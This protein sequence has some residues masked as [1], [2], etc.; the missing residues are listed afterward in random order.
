[1]AIGMELK[2]EERTGGGVALNFPVDDEETPSSSVQKVPPRRLRRRLLELK[3]PTS[4]EE[5]EAKLREADLRRQQFYE[6]LSSRARKMQNP[7][8]PCQEGEQL[9]RMLA[10]C[11]R[12]FVRLKKTTFALAK[13]YEALGISEKDVKLMPFEQLVLKLESASTI[14]TVK[15]LVD[16]LE[17]RI[18]LS[19]TVAGGLSSL[20]N[21]DHL[22]KQLATQNRRGNTSNTKKR[23][24][25]KTEASSKK[26]V[27]STIRPPRYPVRVLLCAY[28][29]VGHPDA[30]LSSK[31]ESETALVEVAA[32]FVQ[33]FELIIKMIIDGP[34][35]ISEKKTVSATPTQK[36]FRSQ[37]E[38]FDKAWCTYL[39]HFV[40]WKVKD[41]KLLEEDLVRAARDLELSMMHKLSPGKDDG[42]LMH[43]REAIQKQVIEN[44]KI[45]REKLQHL[46]GNPEL[47]HMEFALSDIRSKSVEECESSIAS[48][49]SPI[50]FLHP[51]SSSEDASVSLSNGIIFQDED[52]ES[53][54]YDSSLD[55]KASH[56]H[57]RSSADCLFSDAMFV[58]EN[59][60]LVNE[61]LH[62]RHSGFA[63]S[64]NPSNDDENSFKGKVR[65]TMEKA[66]WDAVMDSMKQD[67]PDFSWIIKLIKEVRDK[68]CEMSP[69]SW[70]QEIVDTIDIEILTQVLRSGALNVDY[71]GKVLDFALVTL[72]KLSSPAKDIEIQITHQNLLKELQ[73]ISQSGDKLDST[74]ALLMVKGLRF[75]L[76]QIQTLKKEVSLARIKMTEPLLKG[77]AGVDYLKKAFA[78]RYGPP[79]DAP[80]CLPLTR[81]WLSTVRVNAEQEWEEHINFLSA[82]ENSNRR[83]SR[84]LTPAT[85]RSGGNMPMTSKINV[86]AYTAAGNAQPECRREKIDLCIR[87]GLLKLV[88]EIRGL[89]LETLPETL[90][91]N[92][93]RLRTVQS[94]LQ[95]IVVISTSVLVFQQTLLGDDLVNSSS[96]MEDI[97]SKRVKRLVHLLDS[98]EDA[99]VSEI[100]DTITDFSEDGD[101]VLALDKVRARKQVMEN[102]LR[103]SLQA[104]DA[105]YNLISRAVYLAARGAVL[106][107]SGDKGRQLVET[108][109][110]RV[111]AALLSD[112]VLEAAE[113]LIVVAMVSCRVHGAWYEEVLKSQ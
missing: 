86:P 59:E 32:N 66:F 99:G 56:M 92:L 101:C 55:K 71:L 15:A 25:S 11:W 68:L 106:G 62:T 95:K 28:M 67:K 112:K 27:P 105:V 88:S 43:D 41:A 69:Q 37:L 110:K 85:L 35:Q 3:T 78:K 94:Q 63:N 97:I 53:S 20:E 91:L 103:K 57:S 31:G 52:C 12:R 83:F 70:R 23:K 5:I 65:E 80:T 22:L 79:G 40:M 13:A 109:L 75:V 42:V 39:H 1:M 100:I 10:R 44:E 77:P 89:T 96:D 16:R 51:P 29:I 4:A 60:I 7:K 82:M 34:K 45:L 50:S 87:L 93:S 36:T 111:G 54:S 58:S 48:P 21:I 74:S 9:S 84:G 8:A 18:R 24:G 14:Q 98:V 61:I 90:K 64:F 17:I 72:R 33:E 19:Q 113:I 73:E 6:L 47:Q 38:A 76:E 104:G 46:S 2:E 108:A 107:G 30:V 26:A 102:M 81:Q 49:I